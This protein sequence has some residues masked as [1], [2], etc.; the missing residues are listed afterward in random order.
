[1]NDLDQLT[2][3]DWKTIMGRD[4]VF[5]TMNAELL[6]MVE[7]YDFFRK[8]RAQLSQI[9]AFVMDRFDISTFEVGIEEFEALV[10]SGI[11]ANF[12]FGEGSSTMIVTLTHPEVNEDDEGLPETGD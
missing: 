5:K 2:P 9:L 6:N 4:K 11:A 3:D 8:E 10:A 1:M 7:A 12:K